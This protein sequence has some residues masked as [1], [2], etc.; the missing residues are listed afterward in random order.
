MSSALDSPHPLPPEIQNAIL[1]GPALAP[2]RIDIVPNFEHPPNA[3]LF[4]RAITTIALVLVTIVIILR[5]YAKMFIVRKLQLQDYLAFLAYLCFIGCCYAL[6]SIASGVGFFVHQWNV[7]VR[8][9]NGLIFVSDQYLFTVLPSLIGSSKSLQIGVDF[10]AASILFVKTSILL[11]WLQ[12]FAP[13]GTRGAL[14]WIF[15]VII[16]FN[17]LF[18]TSIE[19]AGNLSCRPFNRIWDK[20]IPEVCFDR[21]PL[22]LTSAGVNLVCD[23]VI[24]LA[25]QRVIWQLQLT[26]AK[27]I[28]LSIIFAIGL[29]AI[30][31]ATGRLVATKLSSTSPDF[32]YEASKVGLCSIY[33]KTS[34]ASGPRKLQVDDGNYRRMESSQ[35]S[36]VDLPAKTYQLSNAMEHAD[37]HS[38]R[39]DANPVPYIVPS[40]LI[41]ATGCNMW[42]DGLTI[43]SSMYDNDILGH[44]LY[45]STWSRQ[46]RNQMI[47]KMRLAN[48]Y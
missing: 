10:Y 27:K 41:T 34:D 19:V 12:I 37:L 42:I 11:D 29:F 1:N 4:A 15:H 13:R 44:K 5:A 6:Y 3:N 17:A 2:P 48:M 35:L 22:D 46:L 9:V 47:G 24:L 40:T 16:W 26:T 31:L 36:L 30:A 38:P 21:T 43:Y 8:D 39:N 7:L 23:I 28:G 18:Y 20:S 45:E 32:T 25:P 33:S 14:F